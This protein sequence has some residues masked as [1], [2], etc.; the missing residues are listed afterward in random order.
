[1]DPTCWSID[2]PVLYSAMTSIY[3]GEELVDRLQTPFGI[4]TFHFDP[5]RGF[6]LNGK[7]TLIKGLCMHHDAGVV[8]AAVPE[9]MLERRLRLVKAMGA[10]AV[11]CSHN[12]MAPEFYDL[13]DRLGLLV[14]DEAFDEWELGKR[15]WVEGRNVGTAERYG[16]SAFFDEWGVRDVQDM[17]LRDRNHPSIILWS[18]GN[19]IDYPGDP[20]AHPESFDPAVPPVEEGSPSATRLPLIAPKLI[21]AIKKHDPTRPVTMALSNLPASNDVGLANMLDAVGYN[22]QEQ[23]YE[24]DHRDFPGRVIYGSENSLSPRSWQYVCDKDYVSGLF[25]WVGFDFLGEAGEWPNHGSRSGLFDTRGFMKPAG[26][27]YKS[28]WSDAPFVRLLVG[29]PRGEWRNRRLNGLRRFGMANYQRTWAAPLDAGVPI[30]VV[31]NCEKV[32]LKLNGKPISDTRP[33]R[34]GFFRAQISYQA[35]VL[36]VEGLN[37][38]QV[39][40]SDSLTTP[41]KPTH[42]ELKSDRKEMAADG[43]DVT[44][45]EVR[46]V[47]DQ[48]TVVENSQVPITITVTGAARLLGIDNGNQ[49]DSTPLKSPTKS[50]Q[51][52]RLLAVLQALHSGGTIE[53]LAEGVG[54]TSARFQLIS[55]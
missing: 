38:S 43:E 53:V 25:L 35:G 52:G 2:T 48:G 33:D 1:M 45:V 31:S 30:L 51:D 40:A 26:W 24:Q 6:F 8:G 29:T 47:D 55:K 22:Y 15:K 49:D 27:M 39:V 4:R 36:S 10:N 16:S 12:P 37:G 3:R 5:N 7:P 18:I 41:G 19:E 32:E 46:I 28:F 23:F 20:Y 9:G 11:R 50:P 21:A 54:L 44:H 13:C 34:G 42:I 17:V 14:M